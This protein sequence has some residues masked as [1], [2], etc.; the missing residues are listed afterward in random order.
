[1]IRVQLVKRT[2]TTLYKKDGVVL[3]LNATEKLAH[4]ILGFETITMTNE[5]VIERWNLK[6]KSDMNVYFWEYITKNNIQNWNDYFT[7]ITD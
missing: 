1:M 4:S 7:V 6:R 3:E 5:K 2:V